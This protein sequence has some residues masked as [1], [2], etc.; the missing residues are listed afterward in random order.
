MDNN[1]GF[2]IERNPRKY[3]HSLDAPHFP[4]QK[5][6]LSGRHGTITAAFRDIF[7]DQFNQPVQNEYMKKHFGEASSTGANW[8][9]VARVLKTGKKFRSRNTK[10]LH[11]QYNTF[12]TCYRWKTSST[13]NCPLCKTKVE[14]WDHLP[15]C[16][17]H[18]IRRICNLEIIRIRKAM[19]KV[20]TEPQLQTHLLSCIRAYTENKTIL[21]PSTSNVPMTEA[22]KQ[23]IAI[24][25]D[26]FM[27]GIWSE[28]WEKIQ[29]THYC[30]MEEKNDKLNVDVWSKRMV[31]CMFMLYR[32]LWK[33]RCEINQ[34]QKIGTL[35]SRI[36]EKTHTSCR[37]L[38]KEIWKFHTRDRH[39]LRQQKKFFQ[40]SSI[41]QILAW[42]K[43][44]NNALKRERE[45][46]KKMLTPPSQT[47][48]TSIP[49]GT[50]IQ[51]TTIMNTIKRLKQTLL[52]FC[53]EIRTSTSGCSE[54]IDTTRTR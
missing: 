23:Q 34:A 4:T 25:W 49:I 46:R 5:L 51:N 39:L 50:R 54:T 18:E 32:T 15:R 31:E 7:I 27:K 53:P 17:H 6:C 16:N 21:R 28:K 19:T 13:A 43:R 20:K 41:Q 11:N 12:D 2:F 10:M 26:N 29:H 52:P 14:S 9:H 35:D 3:A 30:N 40:L 1:V 37:Q 36:R 33:E 45:A 48:T 8:K 44:V 38:R 22:H 47:N 42:E 24:R